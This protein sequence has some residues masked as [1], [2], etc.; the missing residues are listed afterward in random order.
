MPLFFLAPGHSRALVVLF[1]VLF[2]GWL[3]SEL[4]TTLR[5]LPGAGSDLRDR[6]SAVVVPFVF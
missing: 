5:R 3:A 4:W 2:Y 1:W 6:G